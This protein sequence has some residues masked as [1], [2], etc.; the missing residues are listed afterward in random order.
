M[1]LPIFAFLQ[2]K[3]EAGCHA[4]PAS[5]VPACRLQLQK[6]QRMW[7]SVPYASFK[8]SLAHWGTGG[9]AVPGSSKSLS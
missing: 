1:R 5:P 8:Y 9:L 2:R 7:P 3:I 6:D 4:Q